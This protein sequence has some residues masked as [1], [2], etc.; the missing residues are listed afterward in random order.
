[1]A[2]PLIQLAAGC[3]LASSQADVTPL[4]QGWK[5][6]VTYE[7]KDE[8]GCEGLTVVLP[9]DVRLRSRA[10]TLKMS[11]DTSRRIDSAR[12]ELPDRGLDDEGVARLDVPE[13]KR[14]D[15]VIVE[16]VRHWD[17]PDYDGPAG[18]KGAPA[19]LP[20]PV[21]ASQA[22]FTAPQAWERAA[23]MIW[24]PRGVDGNTPVAGDAA[25]KRGAAD[26]RGFAATVAS[27]ATKG[28]D[29]VEIARRGEGEAPDAAV[30]PVWWDG[31]RP[32]LL[33]H[34]DDPSPVGPVRT[35]KGVV[36]PVPHELTAPARAEAPPPA[37]KR[38]ITLEIPEGDPQASLYP[39]AGSA[40]LTTETVTF[41]PADAARIWWMPIP[42]D[43]ADLAV[44]V[45]PQL[46]STTS[47]QREDG[48]VVVVGPSDERTT[49][50][51][52]WRKADAPT[53]GQVL[54]RAGEA[55][56]WAVQDPKGRIRTEGSW[57][58]LTSHDGK[59]IMP[60][61][62]SV[63]N[64]LDW[65]F[66]RQSLPEPALPFELK[67]RA[68]DEELIREMRSAL[69]KRAAVADLPGDPLWP[70]KLFKAR[71]T[72]V[73]DPIEAALVLRLYAQQVRLPATWALARPAELGAGDAICPVGYEDA[74]LAVEWEGQLRWVDPACSVCGTFELRPHLDGA[75]VYTSVAAKTPDVT[76]KQVV[77][78]TA[79]GVAV[80]LQGPP[81]LMLR[82]W[83]QDVAAEDRPNAIAARFA[84]AGAT[85]EKAEGIEV[86]G[87]AIK[88]LIKG[89]T[90]ADPLA[91]PEPDE[92]GS[93]WAVW[94]G[95]RRAERP[96]SG[97]PGEPVDLD[98]G[99]VRYQRKVEDGRLV[100]ILDVK[101]RR[102]PADA[103]AKL[104]AAR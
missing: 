94:A 19:E 12:W 11:D 25:L 64:G 91:L 95:E 10:A 3:L 50:T 92:D 28:S 88:L 21:I 83:L 87:G 81:A 52:S 36:T 98:L 18:T 82:V 101:D 65:R 14:R 59:P 35:S 4:G 63:V 77:R 89:P 71:R 76:G 33:A 72:E 24:L 103:R 29:R 7:V 68:L 9:R 22:Q 78:T 32:V 16:V 57:W 2:D 43:A 48:L 46:P 90:P 53:C 67:G 15:R 5:E 37:A 99:A 27:L 41:D 34:P 74:A 56:E 55:L 30:V 1:L 54:P 86:A 70:R 60:D 31:D 104:E 79:D 49:V 58:S 47:R 80:G 17:R 62:A 13:M 69:L 66:A 84:G 6:T 38:T 8:G 45:A 75:S 93:T 26:D 42:A 102:I 85:L 73:L 39:G 97:E 51:V 40:A 61:R 23:A 44:D 96:L 100:E 20:V